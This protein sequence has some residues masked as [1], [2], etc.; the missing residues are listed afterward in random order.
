MKPQ[1]L[2]VLLFIIT[3]Y[4]CNFTQETIGEERQDFKLQ[5][6][7][8]EQGKCYAKCLVTDQYAE[9][10]EEYIVYTGDESLE[11]VDFETISIEIKAASTRWVKKKADKNCQSADP[12]DCLV[13]CLEESPAE[14]K[15][16]RVLKD[17]SQTTNYEIQ[18]IAQYTLDEKGGFTEWR[19]VL[20]E[21]DIT[22]TVVKRIQSSLREL[23]YY[24]GQNARVANLAPK[25]KASLTA[26][27][28]DHQLPVGNLDF[29]TLDALGVETN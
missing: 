29:E 4:Q 17:T 1:N 5:P 11:D 8:F 16:I 25:T 23:G 28:K 26:Y 18:S 27:Q 15:E 7:D 19:E 14:T 13:W 9:D 10:S 3:S 20:C 21:K 6:K 24:D 22:L 2:F 12:D